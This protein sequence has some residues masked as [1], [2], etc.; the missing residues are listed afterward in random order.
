MSI[1]DLVLKTRSCR[2]FHENVPVD[3]TLLRELVDLARQTASGGNKQPLKYMLACDAAT[4]ARVF[5]HLAWAAYLRPWAGPA[6][7]ERPAA[8]IVI[9]GDT[10][11]ASSF[12]CDQGIAAQT[13]M[14]GASEHGLAGC[15]V[16]SISRDELRDALGIPAQYEIL[17]VL[18]L[19]KP[20]ETVVLE[21]V[22]NGGIKYWRDEQ[23]R[24][25]VPKRSL[26]DIILRPSPEK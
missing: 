2:R 20:R 6:A 22:V 3:E 1:R 21:P 18:A 11:I 13:I 17:L 26:D 8:Y 14:L 16:G 5:P 24:H 4:N 10:T 12:G 15:M 7:G 25:H 19:G 23:G 9:L